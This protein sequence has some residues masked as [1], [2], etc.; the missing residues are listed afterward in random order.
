MPHSLYEQ[1]GR[2][3]DERQAGYRELFRKQISE[4]ELDAIREARNKAWAL[5]SDRFKEKNRDFSWAS[6]DT[7]PKGQAEEGFGLRV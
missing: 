7:P 6:S 5:G 2:N 1:I 4:I 3:A